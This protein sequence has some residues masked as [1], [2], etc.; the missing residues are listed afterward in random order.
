MPS[1]YFQA[2]SH[3]VNEV[4]KY[5]PSS[6]LDLGV[7]FGKYGVILR[8]VLDVPYRRYDREDWAV[9]IDGIEGFSA[10]RN[11]IHDFVYNH[12]H[13]GLIEDVLPGLG[14]YDVVL[15]VDLVEHFDKPQ[16]LEVLRL[17]L[18]HTRSALIVST[19]LVPAAL[20][21]YMGNVL[22]LHRSAWGPADFAA[23]RH[24]YCVI[25]V[26]G[27]GAQVITIHAGGYAA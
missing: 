1:S 12:A 20:K 19:P 22:D 18:A 7:G 11:P 10:Y 9:T 17:A 5:K 8:E 2:I 13:Y 26:G 15:M 3:I 27:G 23:F 25:P 4:L 24:D 16:G 14:V 6:V 21:P